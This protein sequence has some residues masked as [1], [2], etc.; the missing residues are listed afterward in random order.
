MI[1]ASNEFYNIT[2]SASGQDE[3]NALFWLATRVGKICP[4]DRKG[5]SEFVV[6]ENQF[7]S[8]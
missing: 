1:L 8:I 6:Q 4:F 2:E 5:F 7:L 3:A